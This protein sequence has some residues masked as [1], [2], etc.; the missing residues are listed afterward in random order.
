MTDSVNPPSDHLETLVD[1]YETGVENRE[2]DAR[3]WLTARSELE[4]AWEQLAPEQAER[5]RA[6]DS[7][8]I[9]NAG[10]VASQI[11]ASESG[12]LS[13]IRTAQSIPTDQWWWYLDVLS[14]VSDEYGAGP[15]K[16]QSSIWAKL[17]TA[18]EVVVLIIAI[19]LLAR[20]ILPAP[21]TPTATVAPSWTPA[22]TD[23][24]N[25]AAFDM[26]TATVFKA[27]NDIL[28]I[29]LPGLWQ[30][31]PSQQPDVYVF[32]YGS[33]T[34]SETL[35]Q[36][37][38]G[39]AKD[40]YDNV[41]HLTSSVDSPQAALDA[42]KKNNEAQ[43]SAAGGGGLA[44]GN[45]HPVKVGKL[46]GSGLQ[47]TVPGNG[48]GPDS[49]VEIWVAP[50]PNSDK[51]AMVIMQGPSAIWSTA[52]PTLYKMVASLVLNPQNIPT[53]TPTPTLHPLRLTQTAVEQQIEALTPS[54]TPT[55]A[56]TGAATGEA[57]GA[58]TSAAT[59]AATATA[60]P[61]TGS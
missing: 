36:V 34:Q 14:H 40:L 32:T 39:T 5:V 11:A 20:N 42:F 27:P 45:T 59:S 43:A 17:L 44:F 30:N 25:P 57:T 41:L 31:Q 38:I 15:E 29:Q 3:S 37:A 53:P 19:V 2:G 50:L 1:Q 52:Q 12:S 16:G 9:Q 35:L 49:E 7:T 46:D 21:A 26:S 47:I 22:P 60:I 8:L 61:T 24:P 55:G 48:Q 4:A 54:P 6:A 51:V 58:A 33:G 28:E 10:E 23:T 18:V 13:S 56:A